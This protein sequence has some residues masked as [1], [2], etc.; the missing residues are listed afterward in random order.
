M[1]DISAASVKELREKTS[2]GMMDCKKALVECEGD[3][4]QAV[5]WLRKKGLSAAAKKGG[6]VASEGLLAVALNANKAAVIELNS[7]TDFVAR[8]EK[9][10][11]LAQ[12]IAVVALEQGA[13]DVEAIKAADY[14]ATGRNVAGEI[15]EHISVIGENMTLRRASS[16]SVKEGA[17]VSYIHNA[18][19]ENVGK[20][21]VLVGLESSAPADKLQSLGKQ[22]AMHIA[23]AHPQALDIASV[24]A[25]ALEHERVILSDQAKASGKPESIIDKMVEGRI[26][27]YYEEIV[28]LEQIFVI[29][30]KS[31]I[32]EVVE[33]AA[34]EIGSPV[35]IASY[36]CL[37]LGE[38]IEKKE[39]D[40][41]AEVAAVANG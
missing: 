17:V 36:A 18:V 7:E 12:T 35:K 34:K 2:A 40:F 39:E 24:D 20:I 19:A 28:L 6:R 8:N 32:S 37:R 23:A 33:E 9:F 26:R 31:K 22:I 25:K 4:D 41:A 5:D 38:G 14:P 1:A 13:D 21:A 11:K 29:D 16:L 10:Q 3:M 15:N 30:G 27:K